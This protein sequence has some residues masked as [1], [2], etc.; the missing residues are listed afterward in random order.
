M[1]ELGQSNDGVLLPVQ[2]QPGARRNAI[3]GEHGGRLK[4]AVTQVA[5][6]GKATAAIVE[7][8]AHSLGIAPSRITVVQG[9]SQPKKLLC[10]SSVNERE[11]RL[12]LEQLLGPTTRQ[13][14]K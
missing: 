5:E 12:W 9:D 11:V 6:K 8:I 1:I 7:L 3:V 14:S 10:L 4:V 2:G 13:S